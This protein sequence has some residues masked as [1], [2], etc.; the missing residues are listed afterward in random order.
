MKRI[1]YHL[2]L[3]AVGCSALST[4]LG[5][6]PTK[7]ASAATSTSGFQAGRIIDD[8][9]FFDGNAM[10]IPTTQAFLNSKVPNCDTN[11]T[12]M[13]NG[14]Q[15]RAQFS[16]T[17]GYSPPFTCLKDYMVD[18]YGV[19]ADQYCG[20]INYGRYSAA[21]VIYTVGKACNVSQ[22]VLIVLLQKEQGLVTDDW[23]WPIQYT[24]AT[25][26]GCPDT[27]SCDPD[28]SGL[29]N[30]V[31]YAARQYR[32]YAANPQLYNF[33]RGV[34][35]NIAYNPSASCGNSSVALQDQSTAG[36]YNYTPYQP[37]RE[38]LNA[39]YGTAPPCG[40]YGNRNFWL[41]Y[42]DWFGNT[43]G[44]PYSASFVAE[45]T[46]SVNV[47]NAAPQTVWFDLQNTGSQF[48]KDDASALPYYPRTRLM[49]SWPVNRVS[50]FA[51]SSWSSSNR[52]VSVFT[53]VYENDYTTLAADQHTVWP[54]QIARFQFVVNYPASGLPAGNY[55]EHFAL[56]Q[57][58]IPNFWVNGSD[59]WL[60]VHVGQ[61]FEAS[62]SSE[63]AAPSI[64][65]GHNGT[66]SF[67][68]QNNGSQF[69]KDDA[70]ALP[71]YPRTRLMGGSPVNRVS[72]FADPSWLSSNR[73]VSNFTHVYNSDGVTLAAD[74]HT[75]FT[76]QYATFQFPVDYP[77]GGIS[78]GAHRE[79]FSLVQDGIPNFW[80]YNS[81]VWQ[82]VQT[83]H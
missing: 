61:P 55:A 63:S 36:L 48:W 45:A 13:Y 6:V 70:S 66:L 53:K 43:F 65:P 79:D 62:F 74:Q 16:A 40:A 57:D 51:D 81:D 2:M 60:N 25:G 9:V 32:K 73:P 77:A 54:G 82:N 49:G 42:N 14:S 8:N 41:Y 83:S 35:A 67:T 68:L 29:F 39:G 26:Y 78:D 27:A 72:Q 7:T 1:R 30:Q 34:N 5:V 10:D 47:G 69:W 31:Y 71:Y 59:V 75:V 21:G 3:L 46:P 52:P 76:G 58:G 24:A 80:V 56:V 19:A 50:S 15:T 17:K 23:P 4:L 11:G 20:A 64:S 18:F 38:A 28:F 22:K 33:Q 12:Q 44:V 37:N